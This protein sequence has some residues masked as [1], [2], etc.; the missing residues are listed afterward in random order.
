MTFEAI[1][2]SESEGHIVELYDIQD[3]STILRFTSADANVIF[4][5]QEYTSVTMTSGEVEQSQTLESAD[6]VFRI[7]PT[8]QFFG[9]YVNTPNFRKVTITLRVFHTTD[10][11]QQAVVAFMGRIVNVKF[12]AGLAEVRCESLMTSLGR[13]ILRKAFQTQC[14]HVLYGDDCRVSRVAFVQAATLSSVSNNALSSAQFVALG[15]DYLAGGYLEWTN[16]DGNLESRYI[17]THVGDTITIEF[18]I[19]NIAAGASVDVYPGCRHNRT[20]CINKFNNIINYGG[21]PYIPRK[22]AFTGDPTF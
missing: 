17:L 4:G 6:L 3:G 7:D 18:P 1:E 22:N 2:E 15:D 13:P 8:V 21:F 20:D 19:Q 11:D 5:G 12:V 10:P 14:N 9:N 16:G